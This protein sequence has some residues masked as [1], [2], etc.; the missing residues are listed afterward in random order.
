MSFLIPIFGVYITSALFGCDLRKSTPDIGIVR[1]PP[2]WVFG[3]VW[4]VLLLAMGTCMPSQ[5]YWILLAC[6][7]SWTPLKCWALKTGSVLIN[8]VARIVLLMSLFLAWQ[9]AQTCNNSMWLMVAWLSYASL[10]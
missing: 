1:R 4:P 9:L 10:I 6:L 7:A 8:N 3:V 5:T 2:S